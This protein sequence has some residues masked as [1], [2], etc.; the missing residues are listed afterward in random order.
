MKPY[1]EEVRTVEDA[2]A[3]IAWAAGPEGI[4]MGFHPDERFAGYVGPGGARLFTD[5]EAAA[6]DQKMDAACGLLPDQ[7]AEALA[8]FKAHGWISEADE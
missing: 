5:A 2:R 4:G 8:V 7:Y 6:L 3:F 1:S